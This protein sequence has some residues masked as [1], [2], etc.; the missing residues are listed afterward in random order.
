LP[1]LS[2]SA[3]AISFRRSDTSAIPGLS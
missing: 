1:W 3:A 2:M